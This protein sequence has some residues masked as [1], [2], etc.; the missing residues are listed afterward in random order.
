MWEFKNKNIKRN[1]CSI[2]RPVDLSTIKKRIEAGELRTTVDFQRDLLLMFQ[3]AIMY[4]NCRTRVFEVANIMQ[5]ECM[6][7]IEVGNHCLLYTLFKAYWRRNLFIFQRTVSNLVVK[8]LD[9]H[10]VSLNRG[11]WAWVEF[12]VPIEKAWTSK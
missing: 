7:H 1:D 2:C 9:K 8:N 6:Q 4:N 5:N 12:D 3:N 11:I 10:T